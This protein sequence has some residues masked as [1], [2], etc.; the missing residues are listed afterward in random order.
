MATVGDFDPEAVS[1]R[2]TRFGARDHR[3]VERIDDLEP[4]TANHNG[5][6]HLITA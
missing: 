4:P 3:P 5:D 6:R 1:Y 2:F